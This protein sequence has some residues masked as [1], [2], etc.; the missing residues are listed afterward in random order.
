MTEASS[1]INSSPE[2]KNPYLDRR[3]K[4]KEGATPLQRRTAETQA[5]HYETNRR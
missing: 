1:E 3:D 4:F 2:V 5:A